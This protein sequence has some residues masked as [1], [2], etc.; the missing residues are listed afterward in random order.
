MQLFWDGLTEAIQLLVQRDPLV[1]AAAWR[2]LWI[3][4][5]AVCL[6]G[7]MGIAIG[8]LLARKKFVGNWVMVVLF[9]AGMGIPT[10]LI[11]L[12]CYGL[13]SRRGPLGAL[14]LLYTPWGIVLGEFCLALPI[15]VTWIHGAIR[16]LDPRAAETAKTLG[17]G[18]L[19]RWFTY[20][21]EIRLA[22]ALALLT[23]FSRCFTELGIAMMIG[24]NIKYRTR[25]LAT[26]TALETARGEFGRG[27]AM[28]LFLLVMALLVTLMVAWMGR[29]ERAS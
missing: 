11:G 2:S 4:T 24:G 9:R 23:A 15:I 27:I 25:T 14:D 26:A 7:G 12:V 5:V 1:L 17:A 20:L 18:P 19:R 21:S 8:S 29:E 13:L 22:V 3:S 16:G 28:S 10:V 6:A